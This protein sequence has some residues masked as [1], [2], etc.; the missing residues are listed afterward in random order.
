MEDIHMYL[1]GYNGCEGEERRCERRWMEEW[2]VAEV[3]E[4]R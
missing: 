3:T 4:R 1:G 2:R